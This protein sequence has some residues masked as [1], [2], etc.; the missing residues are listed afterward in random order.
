MKMLNLNN[1]EQG[2]GPGP[3]MTV[4]PKSKHLR[5]VHICL[6]RDM[7]MCARESTYMCLY[8]YVCVYV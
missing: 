5:F 1:L 3:L 7:Y 2:Y 4:E 6:E 8:T